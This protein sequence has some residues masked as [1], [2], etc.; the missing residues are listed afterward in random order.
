M[1]KQRKQ[2]K[3]AVLAAAITALHKNGEKGPARTSPQH[4]KRYGYRNNP[5][6]MKRMAEMSKAAKSVELTSAKAILAGAG[7]ASK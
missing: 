4:G 7:S 5:D 3:R 2:E 6:V 1:T